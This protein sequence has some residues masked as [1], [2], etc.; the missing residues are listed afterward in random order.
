[1][2]ELIRAKG[3]AYGAGITANNSGLL[4]TY[5]YRDPNILS[6]VENFDKIGELTKDID[7][8]PRD[9]ENQQIAS[10]GAILRPKSPS[11]LGDEDYIRYKKEEPINPE[12]ILKDI[13]ES[14]LSE[15][16]AFENLFDQA[17]KT[18]NLC[19]FGNR[20]DI[21]EVKEEFDKII[22]LND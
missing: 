10:M 9:F 12:K 7:L 15:V 17:M 21:L 8:T 14:T 20:K 19:A 22:D 16:K 5:S 2:Y 11:A 13:K 3:G 1:M 18:N 6:T 4:S